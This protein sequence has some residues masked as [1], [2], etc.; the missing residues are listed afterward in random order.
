MSLSHDVV[1]QRISETLSIPLGKLADD[2][3][4]GDVVTES[5]AVVEMVIDLQEEFGVRLV[6]DDL[7][8]V[9]TIGALV[10][11]IAARAGSA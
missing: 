10:A 8:D 9:R 6:K 3:L 4:I 2:A 11:L 5:F 7:R 1:R